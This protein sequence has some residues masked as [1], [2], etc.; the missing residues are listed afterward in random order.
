M[1]IRYE[2]QLSLR[3][4]FFRSIEALTTTKLTVGRLVSVAS[5][6]DRPIASIVSRALEQGPK[7]MLGKLLAESYPFPDGEISDADAAAAIVALC[8]RLADEARSARD[9]PISAE[10]E[11]PLVFLAAIDLELGILLS[12]G[13]DLAKGLAI[14]PERTEPI[15]R[16]LRRAG[17]KPQTSAPPLPPIT[18][19]SVSSVRGATPSIRFDALMENLTYGSFDLIEEL[20]RALSADPPSLL[21]RSLNAVPFA[22]DGPGGHIAKLLRLLDTLVDPKQPDLLP[23]DK[24][25]DLYGSSGRAVADLLVAIS[26]RERPRRPNYAAMAEIVD[27]LAAMMTP[28]KALPLVDRLVRR[29]GLIP[30]T[31]PLLEHAKDMVP[32]GTFRGRGLCAVQHLFPS[33]IPV[34][35]AYIAKG[36]RPNDIHVLGT[37]YASNPLVV[38]YARLKGMRLEAARDLGGATRSFEAHRLI[39]I[40]SFLISVSFTG[41]TP[42]NGWTFLDDG[43]ML[44][45]LANGF[46]RDPRGW[47][48]HP[49]IAAAIKIIQAAIA[50]G[51]EQTTR[52]LTELK[53]K[54]LPYAVVAVASARGK[55]LEGRGVGWALAKA[56]VYELRQRDVM[57][58]IERI[59]VVSGG[60]VGL[61]LAEMLATLEF[62]VDVVDRDQTKRTDAEALGLT[63]RS[64]IRES[65]LAGT[66]LVYACTG[67]RAHNP[68]ELEGFTGYAA[69]GSSAAIEGDSDLLSTFG[70]LAKTLGR[71]RPLNF[72]LGDGHEPLSPLQIGITQSL[73]YLAAARDVP[74]GKTGL[75]PL[76]DEERYAE[77]EDR[78][79]DIW[80]KQG[81]S[82]V[83][84][85]ERE[86]RSTLP[87]PDLLSRSGRA[88]HREWITF[89]LNFSGPV[90]PPLSDVLCSPGIYFFREHDGS[91][92][93]VDTRLG[94]SFAMQLERM[95]TDVLPIDHPDMTRL[96]LLIPGAEG[97]RL[98]LLERNGT[99]VSLSHLGSIG[100]RVAAHAELVADP[101]APTAPQGVRVSYVFERDGGL[102]LYAPGDWRHPIDL[103][104]ASRLPSLFSW[105]AADTIIQIQKDP[106]RAF[107]VPASATGAP[108]TEIALPADL[109]VID[110][111]TEA[112]DPE[113]PGAR[114]PILIG[115]DAGGR[116]I[117]VAMGGR[118]PLAFEQLPEGAI[119]RGVSLVD[120]DA[121]ERAYHVH[122]SMPGE[123]DELERHSSVVLRFT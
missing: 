50:R 113:H 5:L 35:E 110:G 90:T 57:D 83:E 58:A 100:E 62:Q 99:S 45:S 43:G 60:T 37:D 101:K 25:V 121:M 33:L 75:V 34:L 29:D 69:S 44:N 10:D 123:P 66:D 84:K 22:Y 111:L 18:T 49:A 26:E 51:I 41:R 40:L 2:P 55:A 6:A 85:I 98:A 71:L 95:P 23:L 20:D 74:A 13:V 30:K 4:R 94:S 39:E 70:S 91:I 89:F 17:A 72:A 115:R 82:V 67:M 88:T 9:V 47:I 31:L 27:A 87:R 76:A 96:G 54:L 114:D 80:E 86:E 42:Q 93:G 107:R 104:L 118:S 46:K 73:L 81:G 79:I 106:A 65:V 116:T 68:F 102:A 16:A 28:E 77:A 1:A 36:M 3:Y 63:A 56:L 48:E 11:V 119:F 59:S 92:R 53:D 52:G 15:E 64:S 24:L 117:V 105:P 38:S 103:P 14:D 112:F 108:I 12:N 19:T 122:Y 78:L 97:Q 61:R 109:R 32:N 8:T 120:P 21:G 7:S